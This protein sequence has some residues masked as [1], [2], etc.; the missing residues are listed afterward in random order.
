MENQ[1]T[2]YPPETSGTLTQA[3]C[4][5]AYGGQLKSYIMQYRL[6]FQTHM[7]FVSVLFGWLPH[8]IIRPTLPI[9]RRLL[10]ASRP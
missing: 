9:S 1:H 8:N 10:R 6:D 7:S 4:I 3:Q 5:A 2:E